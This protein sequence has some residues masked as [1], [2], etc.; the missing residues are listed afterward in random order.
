MKTFISED[1]SSR[2]CISH[3][4]THT[5]LAHTHDTEHVTH[6]ITDPISHPCHL[7]HI[8]SHRTCSRKKMPAMLASLPQPSIS[9]H[10]YHTNPTSH[11]CHTS[12]THLTGH[13]QEG[14]CPVRTLP[15]LLPQ[16]HHVPV[17]Y[18]HPRG[19]RLWDSTGV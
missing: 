14:G 10:T 12:I 3:G 15:F 18:G 8:T 13:V 7:S 6:D 16:L 1:E 9:H 2:A 5:T 11:P 17:T 19:R 4:V